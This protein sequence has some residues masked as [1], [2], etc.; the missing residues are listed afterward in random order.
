MS[1]HQWTKA[2]L[3]EIAKLKSLAFQL[4]KNKQITY[5]HYVL[6]L[7][8]EKHDIKYLEELKQLT[9][10]LVR[11][12]GYYRYPARIAACD[13]VLEEWLIHTEKI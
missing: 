9:E 4:Y 2:E 1:T 10:D 11:I 12:K 3:R 8:V 7:G 13:E 6:I 5:K